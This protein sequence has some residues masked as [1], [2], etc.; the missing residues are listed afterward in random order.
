MVFCSMC[1]KPIGEE[2]TFCRHCGA[3]VLESGMSGV[4]ETTQ[5]P[6]KR[7]LGMKAKIGIGIGITAVVVAIGILAA[8]KFLPKKVKVNDT[9]NPAFYSERT[10][11][12][13]CED[14]DWVMYKDIDWRELADL[15]DENADVNTGYM[16]DE[17][18][19]EWASENIDG[20]MI[21]SQIEARG[22]WIGYRIQDVDSLHYRA[23]DIFKQRIE[24]KPQGLYVE[25]SIKENYELSDKYDSMEDYLKTVDASRGFSECNSHEVFETSSGIYISYAEWSMLLPAANP[26]GYVQCMYA[27]AMK[28]FDSESGTMVIIEYYLP[29][30][31]NEEEVQELR[32]LGIPVITDFIE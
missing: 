2:D 26:T 8:I 29:I 4:V 21:Y 24:R 9:I 10:L 15:A 32:D 14:Q 5:K 3:Q 11:D 13:W 1:G 25:I 31:G 12:R 22:G 28:Y 27:V 30:E 20:R 16:T 17:A 7:K 18:F 19:E 23:G 6:A